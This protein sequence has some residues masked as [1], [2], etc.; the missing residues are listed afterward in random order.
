MDTHLLKESFQRILPRKEEFAATFY[1]RLQQKHPHLRPL[2]A[3]VDMKRQHSSLLATLAVLARGE[4]LTAFRRLGE[5]HRQHQIRAE[6]YPPFGD[7]L[8]ETLAEFDPEWTAEHRAAWTVALDACVRVMM[9][10]YETSA[11]HYRVQISGVRT[12]RR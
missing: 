7:T 3:H 5:V 10:S 4:D 6:H 9:E 2:F 12:R 8:M 11:T 1:Q